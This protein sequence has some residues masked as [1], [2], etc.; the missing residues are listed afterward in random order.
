M[1]T[2]LWRQH[3][4]QFLSHPANIFWHLWFFSFFWFPKSK[5]SRWSNPTNKKK[6]SL[7]QSQKIL[8]RLIFLQICVRFFVEKLIAKWTY[9]TSFNVLTDCK[10]V[11]PCHSLML[12]KFEWLI[13]FDRWNDLVL[14]AVTLWKCYIALFNIDIC[15]LR[16]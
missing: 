5:C 15:K 8:C 13:D 2:A 12:P 10:N 3:V 14:R 9:H 16:T 6:E 7:I 1:I 4:E 11:S